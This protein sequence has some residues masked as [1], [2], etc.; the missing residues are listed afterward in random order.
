MKSIRLRLNNFGP[1]GPGLSDNNGWIDFKRVTVFIGNQG[2]GKS[3]VAKLFSTFSWVEKALVRDLFLLTLKP[4]MYV[5][6]VRED[7][8]EN[9]PHLDRVRERALA[10]LDDKQRTVRQLKDRIGLAVQVDAMRLTG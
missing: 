6:N 2:S 5:A 4:L 10:E 1:I 7:G 3:T 9:N 8:F